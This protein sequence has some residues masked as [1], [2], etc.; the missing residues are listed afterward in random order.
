VNVFKIQYARSAEKELER[1]PRAAVV[2][3]RE[4]VDDLAEDQHPPGSK[5]IKGEDR[6]FR[7]RV[8]DYRV[9]Y[10]VYE[11]EIVVLVIRI[12]HRKDAY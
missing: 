6:M 12:R 3:I 4:A 10:E 1:L 11:K 9:L 2:R 7:I 5:K 8:G